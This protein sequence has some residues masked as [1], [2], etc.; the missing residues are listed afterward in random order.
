MAKVEIKNVNLGGIADSMY[1]GAGN[2]VA[3]MVGLDIHSE[4]GIIKVNQALTL[5][6]GGTV[7]EFCEVGVSCS[8]GSTYLFG[9]SG[10]VF[11]RQS[12]GTYTDHGT[13]LP[14]AGSAKITGAMEYKGFIY[15]AMQNRL[16]R[17]AIPT[18]GTAPTRSDNFATFGIGDDTYHPMRVVNEVLFIGDGYQVAQVD[19]GTF[20]ANA[21]D[22][23]STYRISA[24]GKY[25]TD[26][27]IGT[28]IASNVLHA[29]I[30]RWNTWSV[31]YTVA[32]TLPHAG[33][34][35]FLEMDNSTLV[36]A[37]TKGH[38]Y[39]FNGSQAVPY[40]RIQGVF[41]TGTNE[42]VKVFPQ[43]TL[44]FDGTPLFGVSQVNG[45]AAKYGVYSLSRY[46]SS[47]PRVFNVD[48]LASTGNETNMQYGAILS[49]GDQFLVAWKDVNGSTVGVDIL[50]LNNKFSGAYIKSRVVQL[51]RKAINNYGAAYAF[52]RDLPANCDITLGW[53]KNHADSVTSLTTK[54]DTDRLMILTDDEDLGEAVTAQFRIGFVVNNNDAPEME[55]AEFEVT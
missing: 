30:F 8:N 14:A 49:T 55:G 10:G 45:N 5:N 36:S 37:G 41:S 47:Y 42:K 2:S 18:A 34:N 13:V 21:L 40:G 54:N 44:N 35:A 22:I 6:D 11:E 28:I 52:Y 19:S 38:I 46:S 26:L 29:D 24:L 12:D 23:E 43:S 48:Y 51:D 32:D 4:P 16:G 53:Y 25:G 1:Q 3:E 17:F 7:D 9:E 15:Y 31:S 33:I 27:L 39:E 20:S 50:D